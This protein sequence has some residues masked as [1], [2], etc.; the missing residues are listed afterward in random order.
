MERFAFD[1]STER[2]IRRRVQDG[3]STRR[4]VEGVMGDRHI[5]RNLQGKFLNSCI[6]PEYLYGMETT[7]MSEKQQMKLQVCEN[8]WVRRIAGV[9]RIVKRKMDELREE[10]GVQ[11]SFTRKLVN[12]QLRRA[13]HV[14]RME[15][16]RLTKR[17]ER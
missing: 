8:S 7:A 2:E 15:G 11:E 5:S 12:S 14:E 4:K 3:A 16:F 9:K 6:T 10:V 13:G 17:V 1:G